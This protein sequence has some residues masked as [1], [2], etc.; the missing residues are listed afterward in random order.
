MKGI[1]GIMLCCNCLAATVCG[2]TVIFDF[3]YPSNEDLRAA[4]HSGLATLHLS[5]D[6]CPGSKG[7]HSLRIE[8]FFS[9]NSLQSETIIGPVLDQPMAILTNQCLAV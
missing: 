1:W 5:A 8:R 3:E 7:S 9:T 6:V 2:Q 4:W